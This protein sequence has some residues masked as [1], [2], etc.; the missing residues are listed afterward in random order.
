MGTRHQRKLRKY[1]DGFNE[2]FNFFLKSYRT[3]L[4]TFCGEDVQ[5]F[6]D[7][8]G[9]DCKEGFRLYEDGQFSRGKPIKTRHP[10]ILRAVIV[11]KKSF[12]LWLDQW[13]DGIADW[14][15]TRDEILDEFKIRNIIIPQSFLKDFDNRLEKKKQKR[16]E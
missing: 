12:G 5:T 15:F 14:C 8:N 10:N 6:Y 3:K 9:V 4:L 16:Y 11:G 7:P 2:K 13:T 1:S